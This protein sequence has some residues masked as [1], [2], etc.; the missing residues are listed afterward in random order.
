MDHKSWLWRKKSSEKTIVAAGK[1]SF[2][3]SR[4][5]EE[6]VEASLDHLPYFLLA[7]VFHVLLPLS[8][9]AIFQWRSQVSLFHLAYAFFIYRLISFVFPLHKLHLPYEHLTVHG[10]LHCGLDVKCINQS[11]YFIL[12]DTYISNN[13]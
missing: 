10:L 6:V 5:G 11:P 7:T 8:C 9:S 3:L 13:I 1:V 12:S 4:P 2:P